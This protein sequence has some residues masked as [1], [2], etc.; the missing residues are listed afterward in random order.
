MIDGKRGTWLVNGLAA[1]L[2]GTLTL[3]A[4]AGPAL[5]GWSEGVVAYEHGD[6][7]G[8]LLNW[9]PLAEQGNVR[10]QEMLGF[11]FDFGEGVPENDLIASAWY[12]L[13]AENGSADAQLNLGILLA[14]GD[15]LRRDDIEAYKWLELASKAPEPELRHAALEV[16]DTLA[17]RMTAA[18]IA[19][20]RKLARDWEVRQLSR[21]AR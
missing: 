10:A 12:E 16:L 11:M 7:S 9:I 3:I 8:A 6:F 14:D 1:C 19:T 18:Q 21:G 20:A 5:A 13:A 4:T 15:G 17:M 2:F